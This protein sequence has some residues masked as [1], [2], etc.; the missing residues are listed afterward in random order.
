M[1]GLGKDYKMQGKQIE[2]IE[3]GAEK[4]GGLFGAAAVQ[5]DKLGRNLDEDLGDI[6]HVVS[7]ELDEQAIML[8]ELDREVEKAEDGLTRVNVLAKELIQ[9]SGGPGWFCLI[10]VLAMIALFLFFLVVYT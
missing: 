2:K 3:G 8:E 6:S 10:L 4:H 5:M 9:K 7:Q 1:G